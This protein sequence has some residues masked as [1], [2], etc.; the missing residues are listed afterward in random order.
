MITQFFEDIKNQIGYCGIWC[1]SCVVGNGALVELNKRYE[2]IV[3][4]YGLKEWGPK[5]I[6]YKE[7]MKNLES[8]KNVSLCPGCLKGG[9]RT[10]CEMRACA[11]DKGIRD[12]TECDKPEA[13]KNV[14]ILEKMRIGAT[15]ADL[16]VKTKKVDNSKL[17]EK[18][19]EEL[20]ER[21]KFLL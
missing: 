18:W 3:K 8:I 21:Y 12:C 16:F 17:I 4:D 9:G 20:K 15:K 14:E 11:T 2:K 5:D 19:T 13:C 1:G 7:F 10:N 6:N